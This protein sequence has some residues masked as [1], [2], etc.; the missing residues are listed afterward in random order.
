VP[1]RTATPAAL[2][3]DRRRLD[4]RRISQLVPRACDR[5]R[6]TPWLAVGGR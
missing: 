1:H 4:R 5:R 2:A 6:G 3:L